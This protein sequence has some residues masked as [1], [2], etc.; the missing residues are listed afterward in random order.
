MMGLLKARL[1]HRTITLGTTVSAMA[2]GQLH[3]KSAL[4]LRVLQRRKRCRT[5][6]PSQILRRMTA[7][8]RHSSASQ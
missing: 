8:A 4:P 3:S 2:N 5:K 1:L 6:S 7:T